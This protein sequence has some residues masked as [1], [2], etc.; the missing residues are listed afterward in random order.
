M[1]RLRFGLVET[2][3]ADVWVR[4]EE[5]ISHIMPTQARDVQRIPSHWCISSIYLPCLFSPGPLQGF[6]IKSI[7]QDGFKLNVWDIGG[8]KAIRPYWSNYFEN[9][10]ALARR[11][12]QCVAVPSC[13]G[14]S[15][16]GAS[17][18]IAPEE[19][20]TTPSI[21]HKLSAS[22]NSFS[23]RKRTST[24]SLGWTEKC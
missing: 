9:T 23:T 7:M 3:I 20:R 21:K 4:S 2:Q 18:W 22:L 8:Q 11:S 12:V 5:D 19:L 16:V 1:P 13:R 17:V 24:V 15:S 14:S 6:N 10:D